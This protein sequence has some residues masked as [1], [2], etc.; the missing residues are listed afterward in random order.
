MADSIRRAR[1]SPPK[2]TVQFRVRGEDKGRLRK[3]F[4]ESPSAFG[5]L[6]LLS[7]SYRT[8]LHILHEI[9]GD[10]G[11][12]DEPPSGSASSTHLAKRPNVPIFNPTSQIRPRNPQKQ[13]QNMH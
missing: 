9:K 8:K 11:N 2:V 6:R 5:D 12:F 1:I 10:M 7:E 4:G 3:T 13:N